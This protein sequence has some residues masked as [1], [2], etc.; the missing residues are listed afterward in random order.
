[1]Q[2]QRHDELYQWMALSVVII[3]TFMA[4]LDTSIVNI[5]IP[6][7]MAVFGSS[8]DDVKWILTA[9]TLALGAIIPLTGYLGDILG[10]KRSLSLRL[11]CF[12]SGLFYAE[13][14]GAIPR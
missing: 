5:A 9:Y 12:P 1:M 2:E 11:P 8:L 13:P 6:K 14:P 4:I 3:G 10:Q 7:L